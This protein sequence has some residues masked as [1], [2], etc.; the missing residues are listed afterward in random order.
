MSQHQ[1]TGV[2]CLWKSKMLRREAGPLIYAGYLKCRIISRMH[3]VFYVSISLIPLKI[4]ECYPCE[5]FEPDKV[6]SWISEILT[7]VNA[8]LPRDNEL[9]LPIIVSIDLSIDLSIDSRMPMCSLYEYILMGVKTHMATDTLLSLGIYG[10]STADIDLSV[11]TDGTVS[12][13]RLSH[14]MGVESIISNDDAAPLAISFHN[15]ARPSAI[16][17]SSLPSRT[18]VIS[19]S[20]SVMKDCPVAPFSFEYVDSIQLKSLRRINITGAT[21]PLRMFALFRLLSRN[22][23]IEVTV[24][25][26]TGT[27]CYEYECDATLIEPLK[28][29]YARSSEAMVILDSAFDGISLSAPDTVN[30]RKFVLS[31]S[32]RLAHLSL[33]NVI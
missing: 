1:V 23:Q 30:W 2:V 11:I 17:Y 32:S 14:C 18:N 19:F 31:L 29:F 13:L 6:S 22:P 9:I 16:T 26:M 8:R 25:A 28:D 5:V 21:N 20:S 12:E 27:A 3:S 7:E 15:W 10:L 33:E 4:N 24:T